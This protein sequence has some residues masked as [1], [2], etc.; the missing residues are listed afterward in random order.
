MTL[1]F[2]VFLF[3]ILPLSLILIKLVNNLQTKKLTLK[4]LILKYFFNR[5]FSAISYF[6]FFISLFF[7][8]IQMF[9][10]NEFQTNRIVVNLD[11]LIKNE[12]DILNTKKVACIVKQEMEIHKASN[13]SKNSIFSRLI[14]KKI[15]FHKEMILERSLFKNHK[16]IIAKG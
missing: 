8:H 12:H 15:N 1:F 13:Y 14:D 9:I 3:T 11:E 4:F 5:K 10:S 6:L 2:F 16:C 7:W